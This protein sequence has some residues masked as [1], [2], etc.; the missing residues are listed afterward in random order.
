METH[1]VDVLAMASV[2]E[3]TDLY[4]RNSEYHCTSNQPSG[5]NDLH[6]TQQEQNALSQVKVTHLNNLATIMHDYNYCRQNE[7]LNNLH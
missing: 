2:D 5:G 3:A 1:A 6:M 4:G 7:S